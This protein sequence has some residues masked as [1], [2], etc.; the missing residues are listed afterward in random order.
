[1][2]ERIERRY[3]DRAPQTVKGTAPACGPDPVERP[4]RAIDGVPAHLVGNSAGGLFALLVAIRE[5][6]VVRSLV[7]CE[8]GLAVFVS[9]VMV[10]LNL[11]R[12]GRLISAKGPRH[13][14]EPREMMDLLLAGLE[15]GPATLGMESRPCERVIARHSPATGRRPGTRPQPLQRRTEHVS[16]S[17]MNPGIDT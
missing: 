9:I 10:V 3:R 8:P 4:L 7:L 6:R 16:L 17:Q 11:G 13:F 12:L 15:A 2:G 1:M 14:G 5:P